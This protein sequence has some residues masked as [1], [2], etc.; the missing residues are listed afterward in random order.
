MELRLVAAYVL[1]LYK[2]QMAKPGKLKTAAISIGAAAVGGVDRVDG[3]AGHVEG[4]D[5]GAVG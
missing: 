1:R 3:A 4:D 2:V 5:P